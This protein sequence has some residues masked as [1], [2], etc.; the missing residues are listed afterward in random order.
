MRIINANAV[1]IDEQDI[2]KKIERCGRVC[3]KSEERIQ[4]GSALS[5][6]NML[7][8]RHHL[9]MTE[10]API[11]LRVTERIANTILRLGHGS[12]L[13]VTL[14]GPEERYIISGNVRAWYNLLNDVNFIKAG[15]VIKTL[16]IYLQTS[17]GTE[18]FTLLFGDKNKHTTKNTGNYILSQQ[19]ILALPNLSRQEALTHLYLT[20]LFTCDRGVS[21]ELVRMRVASFAQE[22]T[23]YCNYSK[24]K[25]NNEITFI[26]PH[27]EGS[28]QLMWIDACTKAE[29]KYFEMLDWGLTPQQARTVLPNS[30]KTEVVMTCNLT[31]WQHVINLRYHGTT[32]AP[33]PQMKE[34]MTIWF[35]IIKAKKGYS[36]WII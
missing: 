5:F 33:H 20:C 18:T 2:L 13:N 16:A 31:E 36:D 29:Q 6:I 12:F 23:R 26:D 21:H 24:D 8:N 32:G 15:D 10:H 9:A 14:N 34:V 7:I 27:F 3:Y 11:V 25:F 28:A 1:E 4:E 30:L 35:D 19:D 17:L 22:S